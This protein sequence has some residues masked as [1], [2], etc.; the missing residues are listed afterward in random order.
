MK[1]NHFE[2]PLQEGISLKE[3]SET[4]LKVNLVNRYN[5]TNWAKPNRHSIW[6]NWVILVSFVIALFAFSTCEKPDNG[7]N[8]N[9]SGNNNG[10]ISDPE[11][12]IIVSMRSQ[13]SGDTHIELDGHDGCW[14]HIGNDDNFYGAGDLNYGGIYGN[15]WGR[16]WKFATIGEISGLGDVT[17]IPTSGWAKN[18]SVT[19]NPQNYFTH[20]KFLYN[21]KF[22]GL[23]LN[24]YVNL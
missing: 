23:F 7:E 8:G 16:E 11:G 4:N 17:K 20:Q 5:S 19:L 13:H 9:N 18:L 10:N 6:K 12:T 1:L 22:S 21:F 24:F 14:F 15:T 2:S 3:N